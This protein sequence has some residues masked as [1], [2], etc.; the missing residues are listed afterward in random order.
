[1]NTEI[2]H[3][4][5]FCGLGGGAAGFNRGRA[6]VGSLEAQ[7]R[8]LGG[9]DSDPASIAD[10]GK[11]TGVPGTVVDLF[12]R[13]Q[14]TAWHGCEPPA[15]WR[16]A[17]PA[18]LRVAADN[19]RPNIVF[20]SA[21]CKGFSNLLAESKS[22]TPKYQA[23]NELTL[24]GLHLALEAWQDDP[25]EMFIFENVPRIASRGRP[26]LDAIKGLLEGYGYAV[27]ESTHDCGELGGLAQSRRR[28]L[29]VARHIEKVP[30]FLYEPPKRPL[31]GVGEILG[32]LPP[33]DDV[34]RGG[35]MHRLPRLQWKTWVRLALVEAGRDWRSLQDLRV[36]GGHL[37]DLGLVPESAPF[38]GALG[39]VG[40]N[41]P[42]GTITGRAGNVNCG[43]FSIADPRRGIGLGEYGQYGVKRWDEPS[44]AVTGKAAAGSG[45]FSVADPLVRVDPAIM[46][47]AAAHELP[48]SADQGVWVIR[49]LDGTWHRPFT[50]LELAAL[51]ALVDPDDP[52]LELDGTSN[53]GWRE[54]IGNAVPA[55]AAAAI[56]GVMGETLLLARSGQTFALGSTPIWVRP[57]AIALSVQPSRTALPE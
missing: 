22:V 21:P 57:L 9:V 49:A 48:D 32:S 8:C 18:D 53:S 27:A 13:E 23:L 35:A 6:R 51:Q 37:A 54:R 39:V 26:L 16:E 10:F 50:T 17:T 19:E 44:Q 29:L 5:L 55:D 3:F 42:S 34:E 45:R 31:R 28:F 36:E 12:S 41:E 47:G 2:T 38:R 40:W 30:P 56:A 33:A 7:F 15:D 11:L 4:H 25:P 20:T 14:Y 24:R 43:R 52:L 46:R 1:M